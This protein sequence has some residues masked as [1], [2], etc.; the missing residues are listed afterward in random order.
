MASFKYGDSLKALHRAVVFASCKISEAGTAQVFLDDP[1]LETLARS[2]I[3][4]PRLE[5]GSTFKSFPPESMIRRD[6][7]ADRIN[8]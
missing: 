2:E 8:S 1:A 7:P 5:S 3:I 4:P 6:A